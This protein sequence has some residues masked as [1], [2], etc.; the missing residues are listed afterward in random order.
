MGSELC[1]MTHRRRRSAATGRQSVQAVWMSQQVASTGNTAGA[2]ERLRRTTLR[3]CVCAQELSVR[4][5]LARVRRASRAHVRREAGREPRVQPCGAAALSLTT[6]QPLPSQRLSST[7]VHCR[8]SI[9]AELRPSVDLRLSGGRESTLHTSATGRWGGAKTV[10]PVAQW[11]VARVAQ[12]RC[13]VP[14]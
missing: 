6:R 3:A 1:V 9:V 5:R 7:A 14:V 2:Y 8:A 11:L 10:I 12:C 13:V 4:A